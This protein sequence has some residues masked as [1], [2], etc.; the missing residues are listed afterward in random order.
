MSPRRILNVIRALFLAASVACAGTAYIWRQHPSL[1]ERLDTYLVERYVHDAQ[2]DLELA[3]DLAAAGSRAEAIATLEARVPELR[4]AQRGDRLEAS[5][6]EALGLLADLLAEEGQ[7]ERALAYAEE[8]FAHDE[9]DLLN[10][11]R[12]ARLLGRLDRHLEALGALEGA[13]RVGGA[14]PPIARAFL[15][16][17]AR[18]G[19][20]DRALQFILDLGKRGPLELASGPWDAFLFPVEGPQQRVR[21]D[22]DLD[23]SLS[24]SVAVEGGASP[25]SKVRLDLPAGAPLVLDELSVRLVHGDGGETRFGLE[26]LLRLNDLTRTEERLRYSEG[27][28][29]FVLLEVPE[30][31]RGRPVVEVRFLAQVKPGFSEPLRGLLREAGE[32]ADRAALI[33]EF[34]EPMVTRLETILH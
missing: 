17:L 10:A 8:L 22:L 4:S 29:P 23:L 21:E 11:L 1:V 28:D 13:A 5:R 3:K 16:A 6:I 12:R 24:W 20:G 7:D 31:V 34:G 27:A 33:A 14:S 19:D 2:H 18:A 15:G 25:L 32:N 30:P 26:Q 9:R